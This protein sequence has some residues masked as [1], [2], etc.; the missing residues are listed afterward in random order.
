MGWKKKSKHINQIKK[1]MLTW[2]IVG[3]SKVS[4]IYIYCGDHFCAR[5]RGAVVTKAQSPTSKEN[6]PLAAL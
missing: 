4:V 6:P 1:K 5:L 3:V 2:K